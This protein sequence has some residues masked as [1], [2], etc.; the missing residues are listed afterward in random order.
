MTEAKSLEQEIQRLFI[1]TRE[2]PLNEGTQILLANLEATV[3]GVVSAH[4]ATCNKQLQGKLAVLQ[5]LSFLRT[6]H[7]MRLSFTEEGKEKTLE[8]YVCIIPNTHKDQT[9]RLISE[10][11]WKKFEALLGDGSSQ[12]K[13]LGR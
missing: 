2:M 12:E 6:P 4:E 8:A 3:L 10:E 7:F 13:G 9:L 11:E 5:A 1:A